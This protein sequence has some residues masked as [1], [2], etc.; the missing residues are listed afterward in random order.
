MKVNSEFMQVKVNKFTREELKKILE[1]DEDVF[2]LDVR[3]DKYKGLTVFIPGSV[4]GSLF[5]LEDRY[6]SIPQD[7]KVIVTDAYMKQSPIAA[8]FLI[9]KGYQI[10]G[11]LKGGVMHWQKSGYDVVEE[12]QVGKL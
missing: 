6:R 1:E 4:H 5:D 8:K 3:P 2:L 9:L 10:A 11:V 7:R 12:S